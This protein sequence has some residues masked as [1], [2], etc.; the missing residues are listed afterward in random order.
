MNSG[1]NSRW[2]FTCMYYVVKNYPQHRVQ[3]CTSYTHKIIVRIHIAATS[4]RLK[5]VKN[6][7]FGVSPNHVSH[8]C[9][10]KNVAQHSER[11]QGSL[12]RAA[13]SRSLRG[14]ESPFI[15]EAFFD[16]VSPASQHANGCKMRLASAR[17]WVG[18]PL[19]SQ[20]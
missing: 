11:L 12:H 8:E 18:N 1:Q 17:C 4:C 7:C 14:N 19:S 2:S 15:K 20:S 6:I 9:T 13:W 16:P 5:P 10:T 3:G